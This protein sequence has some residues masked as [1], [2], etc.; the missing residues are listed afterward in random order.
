MRDSSLPVL[1]ATPPPDRPNMA[2]E[3]VRNACWLFFQGYALAV[4]LQRR[5]SGFGAGAAVHARRAREEPGWVSAVGW[6]ARVWAR[7][8]TWTQSPAREALSKCFE[9]VEVVFVNS[10]ASQSLFS[11]GCGMCVPLFFC[12]WCWWWWSVHERQGLCLCSRNRV[13]LL[14]H[15]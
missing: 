10:Q 7:V 15:G 3:D 4:I 9:K 14:R 11:A 8:C 6:G 2:G 13:L 12:V 5:S 1:V